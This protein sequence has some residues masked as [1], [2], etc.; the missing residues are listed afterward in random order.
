MDDLEQPRI[1]KPNLTIA[2]NITVIL[3]VLKVLF[4]NHLLTT[5][6]SFPVV[7]LIANWLYI[8][9]G[10]LSI[11]LFLMFGKYLDNFE[12]KNV[13]VWIYLIVATLFFG[14]VISIIDRVLE[15]LHETQDGLTGVLSV[16]DNHPYKVMLYSCLSII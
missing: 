15:S 7:Y 16:L 13:K 11:V 2:K 5:L 6:F 4:F 14:M 8:P 10:V 12:L 9:L 1:I 3:V